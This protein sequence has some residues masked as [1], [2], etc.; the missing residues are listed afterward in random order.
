MDL[1]VGTGATLGMCLRGEKLLEPY[2]QGYHLYSALFMYRI[3]IF[4]PVR[5]FSKC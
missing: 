5:L 3:I 4:F 2:L 1:I